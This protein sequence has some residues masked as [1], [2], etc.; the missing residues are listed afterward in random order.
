MKKLS[1]LVAAALVGMSASAKTVYWDN[2]D[3][4]WTKVIAYSWDP[5]VDETLSATTIDGHEVYAIE[6][7]NEEIIF[8][9][10]A[11]WSDPMQTANLPVTDGAVYGKASIKSNGGSIDPIATITNGVWTDYSGPVDEYPVM[12][13]V[14]D[15]TGWGASAKFKMETTDGITYTLS[16][17]SF[18]TTSEFK[19]YGGSWGL[20][21]LTYTGGKVNV[22]TEYTLGKGNG[23]ISVAEACSD[24]TVKLVVNSDYTSGT[25][26]LVTEGGDE[27]NPP[28]PGNDYEGW[29]VNLGGDFITGYW[30]GIAVP[31]DGKV[32]FDGIAIGTNEFKLKV[33][34]GTAD[35]Y[36]TTAGH[37][38]ATDVATVMTESTEIDCA[39]TITG[40]TEGALYDVTFDC[41]TNTITV[42]NHEG[43]IAVT[44]ALRGTII[45]G[46]WVDLE[47]TEDA[48]GNWSWS[49]TVV[50]GDF[51]IKKMENGSQT[52][53]YSSSDAATINGSGTYA[54][55]V[56]GT[57][58][59]SE[60]T[61]EAA[62]T[63][64]P[65]TLV[66]T[67]SGSTAVETV[68]VAEA[69]EAVYFNLQGVRVENPANGLFVRVLN[70]KA[71]KV[72]M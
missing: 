1:L 39:I 3:T 71:T 56:N 6:L 53:W 57:N 4:G 65:E 46:E 32:S 7:D 51:G 2:T 44:Y 14:G 45:D 59:V 24:V 42:V 22:N 49:G 33:W 61:G 63:F 25:L 47:M 37:V 20:R 68:E 8:K 48:E 10:S 66:L 17:Q 54:A 28:T 31:T 72:V 62:F 41:A 55:M 35:V 13:M 60:L 67:A 16:N 70:G 18:T 9:G 5:S 34:N 12:Y 21:E 69:G 30:R 36:Y 38:V 29:Y 19:F 26:T 50:P 27:P 23:N 58:W 43:E 40:A 15:M 52:A 11:A 64:N